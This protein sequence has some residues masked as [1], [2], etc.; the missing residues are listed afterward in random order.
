[1]KKAKF[2]AL[3]LGVL[4]VAAACNNNQTNNTT[5]PPPA[6]QT[7]PPATVTPPPPPPSSSGDATINISGGNYSPST[8]TIKKGSKVTF[9]NTDTALRWPASNPHPTHTDY[10]GFD[11]RKGLA[12][13]ETYSFTFNNV[14][15]WRFH[16]HLNPSKGGT[17]IV[18][19]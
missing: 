2:A 10:A 14:G 4:L 12:L 8:L 6:S 3:A 13:N 11:P 18:T 7:P 9:T 15:S 16:D 5:P 1:M 19:E 17:I